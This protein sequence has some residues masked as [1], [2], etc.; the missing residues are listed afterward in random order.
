[1][2]LRILIIFI[3][4]ALLLPS[5]VWAKPR[6]VGGH[7]KYFKLSGLV[8]TPM[9]SDIGLEPLPNATVV[10]LPNREFSFD[11]GTGFSAAYGFQTDRHLNTEIEFSGRWTS[12]DQLKTPAGNFPAMG[13]LRSFSFMLNIPWMFH[14]RSRWTPY[15]GGGIGMNWM[16]GDLGALTDG[17]VGASKG[18]ELTL[19]YQ[20]LVGV[21]YAINSRFELLLGYRFFG[22]IDAQLG[23]L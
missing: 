22:A 13:D 23:A 8:F 17:S 19:A 10:S 5:L 16:R 21:G 20:L 4:L 12:L 6:H 18:D 7:K 15:A 1:M 3:S 11:T 9:D 2:K 14:N